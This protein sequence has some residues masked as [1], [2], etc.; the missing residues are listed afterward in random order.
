MRAGRAGPA[1]RGQRF[2][3]EQILRDP[4][5]GSPL[6]A[7]GLALSGPEKSHHRPVCRE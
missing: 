3:N 5:R 1:L 7:L 2:A 6:G 4:A